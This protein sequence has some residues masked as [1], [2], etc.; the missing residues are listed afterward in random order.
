VR[1]KSP[2]PEKGEGRKPMKRLIYNMKLKKKM[3]LAPVVVFIFMIIIAIGTYMAISIQSNSIDD[4]YNN[5]FKGYQNSSHILVEMS[6]VQ[7]NLYK[8]MNWI[9]SNYDKQR[10]DELAK[11]TD[12]QIT[13]NVEFTKKILHSGTLG[14]EEKKLYTV[15]YNNLVE[16]HKLAKN[17]LEIAAQDASTAVMTFSMAEDKF[18]DV[19]KSLRMLNALEDKLSKEQ[20]QFSIGMA[21]TTL[22]IFLVV[23]LI[24]IV[25]SFLTSMTVTGLILKPIRETIEVMRRFAEG[26]LTRDIDLQSNDEIGELVQ[27]VNTMRSKMNNAVGHALEVSGLLTEAASE[28]AASIE[29]TSASLDEIASMTRKN[30]ENTAAANQLM[31]S[32]RGAI[33]QANTSMGQ[34]TGSMQEITKA[35]EQTQKIVK[36]IDEI[37]FQTNLLAL[38]ASVEAARAGEAGAG[39]AV[40][41]DEVR[42]LA[43]RAKESAQNSSTLI[44]DIVLKVKD[45]ENLVNITS[46]AF[47]EV[48]HSS[49]KVV[50]LMSEIAAASRE[51]SQGIDQV[52]TAI[53]EMSSTTQQNAGN[54]ENLSAIMSIFKTEKVTDSDSLAGESNAGGF[55]GQAR[56]K[57]MKNKV[58]NSAKL[59]PH[60]EKN[61]F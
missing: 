33:K 26:D 49:D 60:H 24:A 55:S 47:T 28:E 21:S 14:P 46:T 10:I 22:T 7:A 18:V 61:L 38:N 17:T 2:D 57:G 45:G 20:Y 43:M 12:A 5:R 11:K 9:A 15:A 23:L 35:S 8:L 13:V 42:N 36:S 27:S 3:L 39:F 59:L 58:S 6:T 1:N 52:N 41:A 48:T 16:F 53:A 19:D 30:A 56:A 4:I 29:E 25:V 34:L 32:A 54:A 37:A 31:Q 51:Q 40:V 44:E 50:D